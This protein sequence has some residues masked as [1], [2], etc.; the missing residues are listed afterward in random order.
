MSY[1]YPIANQPILLYFR[2]KTI[3]SSPMKSNYNYAKFSIF[4]ECESEV[5][6]LLTHILFIETYGDVQEAAESAKLQ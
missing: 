1:P 4:I 5:K 2:R 3:V 6:S